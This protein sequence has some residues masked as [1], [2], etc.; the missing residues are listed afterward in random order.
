MFYVQRIFLYDGSPRLMQHARVFKTRIPV[1][2]F[3]PALVLV[4][5]TIVW[6]WLTYGLSFSYYANHDLLVLGVYYVGTAL[7]AILGA[8]LFRRSREACLS[9]WM[10]LG[11]FMTALLPIIALNNI[12]ISIL[13]SLMFGVSTGIGLP[14]CLAYFADVTN[15]ENRGTYGGIVWGTIGFGILALA[16]LIGGLDPGTMSVALALW[17]FFGFVA[18]FWLSRIQGKISLAAVVP[19]YRSLLGRRDILPYLLPWIMFSLV[20]FIET[21]ILR[22]LLGSD[23][24]RAIS[25]EFAITGFFAIV[26]G[27]LADIVGRKRVI[28]TGFVLLGID[29]AVFG[30]FSATQAIWYVYTVLDGIAWGMFAAVFFM[31]VWGDLAGNNQKERYYLLGGLPYLLAAFLSEIVT[32]FLAVIPA[33]T[34]FSLASFFLFVA[35][36]PLMYATETL[37]EKRIKEMELRSYL[38]KAKKAKEKYA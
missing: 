2:R 4:F 25:I 9:L 23:V 19:S 37:P 35:V 12:S 15:V 27:I 5:N 20:N 21:P 14:P 38:E 36:L 33:A 30:L 34:A 7:A 3:A 26:G 31:T 11:A 1:K 6:Y 8:S 24:T 32:P 18:F 17:R 28:I 22:N 13:I 16:L 10:L 29:Y